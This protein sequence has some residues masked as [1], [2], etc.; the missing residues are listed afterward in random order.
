MDSSV[1]LPPLTKEPI[2]KNCI[3]YMNEVISNAEGLVTLV[4]TGCLTN[5]A[6]LISVFPE[7][8]SKI[9]QIVLMGGA[10]VH[11]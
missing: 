5:V 6:L 1:K 3:V 9:E 10:V 4:C 7:I 11:L 8:T 2:N